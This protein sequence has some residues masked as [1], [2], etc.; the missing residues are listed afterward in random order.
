MYRP[1][2]LDS[3]DE[4]N[5]L[6]VALCKLHAFANQYEWANEIS[7]PKA[8]RAIRAF[9]KE[10]NA[11]VVD[12]Y[13]VMVDTA[14]PWFSYDT[15]LQ[16]W[17]VL[18]LYRGGSVNSIPSALLEIAKERG[19]KTVMSADSSPISIVAKAYEDAGFIPLTRSYFQKVNYGLCQKMGG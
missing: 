13:L 6:T 19:C 10:G 3:M 14:E 9:A 8:N 15:V 12:G 7:F 18:K 11:Y 2:N 1:L 17:L 5:H 4:M 16:E